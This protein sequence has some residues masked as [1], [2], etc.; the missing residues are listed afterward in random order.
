MKKLIFLLGL[1]ILMSC[2]SSTGSAEK[3]LSL[4]SFDLEDFDLY[5]FQLIREEAEQKGFLFKNGLEKTPD[6]L[7]YD[8]LYLLLQKEGDI[9]LYLTTFSHKYIYEGG[10]FNVDF[11]EK[12][13]FANETD[14]LFV[15]KYDTIDKSITFKNP[16]H[17]DLEEMKMLYE[18]QGQNLKLLK[19][20]NA[21]PN[22][23][24]RKKS[25]LVD[26]DATFRVEL[27]FGRDSR[28]IF[29]VEGCDQYPVEKIMFNYK[30]LFY[31]TNN[32][33]LRLYQNRVANEDY[34]LFALLKKNYGL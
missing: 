10:A 7:V 6:D 12:R 11:N 15:G 25:P 34:E 21:F 13:I 28:K 20:T 27:V 16:K 29:V 26:L 1:F 17:H 18:M 3:D 24:M 5:T 9:A 23:R 31:K 30:D 14:L 19:V 8:E 32:G 2:G 22:Q 4:V 33:K